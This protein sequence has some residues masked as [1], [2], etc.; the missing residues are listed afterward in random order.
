MATINGTPASETING[1][2]ESDTINGFGGDDIIHGLDGDDVIDGGAGVDTLYG[3]L[4]NDVYIMQGANDPV[5]ENAGE[6]IDEVRTDT[7]SYILAANVEILTGTRATAQYLNG[8]ELANRIVGL[9]A[10]DDV[11]NGYWGDDWII[12]GPGADQLIGDRGNDVFVVD[13]DD[14]AVEFNNPVGGFGPNGWDTVLATESHTLRAGSY[15]EVLGTIDPLATTPINLTGNDLQNLIYGNEGPNILYGGAPNVIGD[16]LNGAGG[17]D[18]YFVNPND[19]VFE[20][21]GKGHDTVIVLSGSSVVSYTLYPGSHVETMGTIDAQATHAINLTGNAFQNLIYGNEGRNILTSGGG[22]DHLNGGGGDDIYFVT[23][24]DLVFE[25]AGKGHDTVNSNSHYTLYPGSHVEVLGTVD[26][27]ATTAINLTGNAF[28][29]LIYGNEGNNVLASG[30]GGD[31]LNGGGGDDI[32]FVTAGDLVFEN[33]GKGYDTV[34]SNSNYTLYPGS[35]V[36]VLGT[37]DASATTAIN[38]TG[39]ELHN[40]IYGNEGANVL[41]AGGGGDH[42]HGGGGND[43]LVAGAG[44]DL[45]VGGAGVDTFQFQ[46]VDPAIDVIHDF[47]SGEKIDLSQIDA[48]SFLSGEGSFTFIGGNA[49]SGK[50]GELRVL[51]D[52]TTAHILGDVNGDGVADLHISVLNAP[53]LTG[54]DFIL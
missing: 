27:W 28:Q 39:N 51:M 29:N 53:P 35:Y 30:G 18:I 43:I 49:F 8:N 45:M 38:L 33:A 15:I 10:G 14:F 19:L 37:V 42:L 16:H 47:T 54:N 46:N 26:A 52:G 34:N 25:Q 36:E 5:K 41:T 6:G 12:G 11:L 9:G 17:D 24:G 22:G 21:A 31:H 3:G 7:E 32:Y 2:N 23:A 40:L 48:N 44:A 20:N 1:T 13:G 50:A 4:G